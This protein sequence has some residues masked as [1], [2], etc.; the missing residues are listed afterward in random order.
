[1]ALIKKILFFTI[2]VFL[3]VHAIATHCTRF[4]DNPN[5]LLKLQN[6][7]IAKSLENVFRLRTFLDHPFASAS[8]KA[9]LKTEVRSL[10]FNHQTLAG[11]ENLLR[12]MESE[13]AL[14]ILTRDEKVRIAKE[15]ILSR[16]FDPKKLFSPRELT[17]QIDLKQKLSELNGPLHSKGIEFQIQ[18]HPPTA[19]LLEQVLQNSTLITVVLE[20]SQS[21]D[22]SALQLQL[23]RNGVRLK[24]GEITI[25]SVQGFIRDI[26]YGR[27]ALLE[28]ESSTS[29]R[30][31]QAV[32]IR[33][34][35]KGLLMLTV[36]EYNGPSLVVRNDLIPYVSIR[37]YQLLGNHRILLAP[38]RDL[39]DLLIFGTPLPLPLKTIIDS[40]EKHPMEFPAPLDV[41]D[42]SV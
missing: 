40:L 12:S 17:I 26:A 16:A 5:L 13:P 8:A 2:S 37:L 11:I 30:G 33:S 4:T 42:T 39:I 34:I 22:L 15:L 38:T 18:S 21:M 10:D 1:M 19:L 27:R 6:P 24:S 36:H 14:N 41:G 20:V 32:A 31:L 23:I 7:S 9:L 3:S 29:K 28:S 25:N 35:L